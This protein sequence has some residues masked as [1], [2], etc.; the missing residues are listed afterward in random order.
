MKKIFIL[1]LAI[2]IVSY[3]F[4]QIPNGYYNTITTQKEA[5]LK[6][7]LYN[8]IKGHTSLSYDAL[9]N[10]FKTTDKKADGKVWDM[11]SNCTYTFTTNQCGSYSGECPENGGC[12]NREHSWPKSWFNEGTPMYSDL[13]HLVPTDG[14]VNGERGNYPFGEVSSPSYTSGNGSKRG[15]CSFPGYSGTVFEP[16]DEYKGDFARGYFYMATRYENV[17]ANWENYDAN[18][19]AVLNG[20]AFPAFETWTVNLLLKWH[21]QDPVSAKEIARNNAVYGYQD[22]RNPFID[23]PEYAD[24]IWDPTYNGIAAIDVSTSINIY[25]NPNNGTFTIDF[26]LENTNDIATIEIYNTQGQMVYM[27][28]VVVGYTS[29]NLNWENAENGVY[30]VRI[31]SNDFIANKRIVISK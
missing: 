10:A 4:A 2:F 21:R 7:A 31:H 28:T 15:S 19:N 13:F 16:I 12:Y 3:S 1:M 18:G 17:I 23:H 22:N 8:I 30:I 24:K 9:W 14:K 6:T 11:Y 26:A 29:E 27:K 5:V 25:P 20:T